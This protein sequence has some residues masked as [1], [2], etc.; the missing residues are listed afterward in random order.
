MCFSTAS[1]LS[2]TAAA[3]PLGPCAVPGLTPDAPETDRSPGNPL[4][5]QV[6]VLV[7]L[8]DGVQVCQHLRMLL[9]IDGEV[10]VEA[11]GSRGY[12]VEGLR[13]W[14]KPPAA[15]T[16]QWCHQIGIAICC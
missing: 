6:G 10:C 15:R 13:M 1:S 7:V 2:R 9:I 16:M 12:A 3:H 4:T 5:C 8:Q 11:S 14:Y